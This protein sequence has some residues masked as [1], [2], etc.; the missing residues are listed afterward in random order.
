MIFKLWN[1]NNQAGQILIDPVRE[2][3][4][5]YSNASTYNL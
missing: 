2:R 3:Q 4:R 5:N 1:D